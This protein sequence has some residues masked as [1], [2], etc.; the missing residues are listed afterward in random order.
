MFVREAATVF[1][2]GLTSHP[3]LKTTDLQIGAVL[4]V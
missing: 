2:F 1:R 4:V 3:I